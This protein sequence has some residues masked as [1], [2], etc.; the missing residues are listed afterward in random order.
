MALYKIP[1]DSKK[2]LPAPTPNL[3]V[4]MT[5]EFREWLEKA[6]SH[7]RMTVSGFLEFAAVAHAKQQ[8]F[9]EQAPRH[10]GNSR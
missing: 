8:G 1:A 7:A 9:D 3:T 2:G 4:R 6:A 5:P 10:Q